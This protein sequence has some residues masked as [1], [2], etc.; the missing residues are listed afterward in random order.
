MTTATARTL[1]SWRRRWGVSS[2]TGWACG[3]AARAGTW[4]LLVRALG[5]SRRKV[6][7]LYAG[8]LVSDSDA[9]NAPSQRAQS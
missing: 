6:S 4:N 8:M 5:A 2:Q 7:S 3:T 9:A 1:L